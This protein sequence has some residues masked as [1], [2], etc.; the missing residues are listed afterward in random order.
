MLVY[1]LSVCHTCTWDTAGF[2]TH[3]S[4]LCAKLW[5]ALAFLVEDKT[6]RQT[7]LTYVHPHAE[8]LGD[9][10]DDEIEEARK[11]PWS[12]SQVGQSWESPRIGPAA[13]GDFSVNVV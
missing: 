8:T 2:N 1:D 11:Q 6:Y 5:V 13:M 10:K 4:G 3:K 7:F 12:K 9:T